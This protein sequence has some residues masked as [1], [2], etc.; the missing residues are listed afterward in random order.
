MKLIHQILSKSGISFACLICD[1]NC[2]FM[3]LLP[4]DSIHLLKK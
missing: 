3:N 1:F 4:D 2:Y